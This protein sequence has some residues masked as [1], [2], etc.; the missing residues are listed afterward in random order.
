M[1]PYTACGSN[2]VINFLKGK[3][4]LLHIIRI[5]Y[6]YVQPNYRKLRTR[7]TIGNCLPRWISSVMPLSNDLFMGVL[8]F[9]ISVTNTPIFYK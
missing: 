7:K 3:V 1:K 4:F 8:F 5:R 2:A 6:E 9:Y